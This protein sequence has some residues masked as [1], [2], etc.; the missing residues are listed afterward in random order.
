AFEAWHFE[1]SV[2]EYS[3]H[4]GA[5][6][7]RT[8]LAVD[9]LPGDG[10]ECF[11]RH[12]EIDPLHLEQPLIL[13]HQRVFRL[14]QNKLQRGLVEILERRHDRKPADEFRDQAELKQILRLDVAKDLA[15]LAVLGR[16]HLGAEADRARPAARRDDL[17]EPVEGAAAYEQDVGGVDLQEFLLR[18]LAAALRRYARD[19]AL[20]DLEQCLLHALARDV[21]G[22]REVLR[23]A[24]N[25][26]DLVDIDDTALRALDVVFGGL[27][28][29]E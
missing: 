23:L 17:L 10:A 6:T 7:P 19:R 26:V 21:A 20:H 18:M 5:Q 13:L 3:L 9:R 2:K 1:H 14:G 16:P 28:Q 12:S 22:D 11:L 15:L 4:D 8:R 24:A 25:L 29:L 27:Q